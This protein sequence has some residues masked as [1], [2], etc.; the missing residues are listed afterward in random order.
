M[1]EEAAL[2]VSLESKQDRVE[3]GYYLAKMAT[4]I[5]FHK[6]VEE[7]AAWIVAWLGD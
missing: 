6:R 4:Y 5:Y 7:F 2:V 1:K 3:V